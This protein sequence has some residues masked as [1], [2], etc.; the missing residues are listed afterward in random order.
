MKKTWRHLAVAF[1]I[2][3]FTVGCAPSHQIYSTS[4]T[5]NSL[6]LDSGSPSEVAALNVLS[7]RCINC[8]GT[9]GSGGLS[10]ITDVHKLIAAGWVIPGHPE[11]S[12]LAKAVLPKVGNMPQG[13]SLSDGEYETLRIWILGTIMSPPPMLT[14]PQV[15]PTPVSLMTAEATFTNVS[16]LILQ[17]KC[18]SCHNFSTYNGTIGEVMVGSPE[19]SPIYARSADGSMPQIGAHL[20]DPELKLLAAWITAG[21]LN[22]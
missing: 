19:G 12:P 18:M 10:N 8:H 7:S 9:T 16:R 4:S 17:P 6:G 1:L 21:A 15:P 3:G 22:N 13:G 20:T 14:P 5:P 11:A 2:S